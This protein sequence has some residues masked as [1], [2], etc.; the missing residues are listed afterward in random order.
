[1]SSRS[2]S[3][4][5]SPP[6]Y[7]GPVDRKPDRLGAEAADEPSVEP[8]AARLA[9][10]DQSAFAEL[11]DLCGDRLYQ[12]AFNRLAKSD[13]AA[14]TVQTVFLRAV[15]GRRR[16]RKV[17]NPVAYMFQILRNEMA[18]SWSQRER[19]R[20]Q[21]MADGDLLQL[22]DEDDRRRTVEDEIDIVDVLARLDTADREL[23]ELKLIAGLT[24]HEISLVVGR[25]LATVATRYRRILGRLRAFYGRNQGSR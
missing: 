15:K 25:P 12:Y 4:T 11:Y 5:P 22:S 9:R 20:E 18:R 19:R 6:I 10:G 2:G 24:F 1:M 13:A 3:N 14:D 16:F 7:W 21:P 17:D 8:L 23:V